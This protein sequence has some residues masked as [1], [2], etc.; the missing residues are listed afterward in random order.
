MVVKC[1]YEPNKITISSN[2]KPVDKPG[3]CPKANPKVQKSSFKTTKALWVT[4]S[5]KPQGSLT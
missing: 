5:S 4:P 1:I 2:L 3:A